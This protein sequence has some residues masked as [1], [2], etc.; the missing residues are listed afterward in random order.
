MEAYG[1]SSRRRCWGGAV[2]MVYVLLQLWPGASEG[3][4]FV[5]PFFILGAVW[6]P[7]TAQWVHLN[8]LHA[9]MNAMAAVLLCWF[10]SPWMSLKHQ[11]LALLGG[12]LGVALLL[13]LDTQCTYYAGASG[14]LHGVLAGAIAHLLRRAGPQRFAGAG[15][16]LALLTK[17][18]WQ[19]AHDGV[20][21]DWLGMPIYYPA[22]G[23]GA[24]GGAL[25]T[26]GLLVLVSYLHPPT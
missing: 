26:L 12:I 16:A 5:R 23:A 19:S 25:M 14:A 2:A 10:L 15:L 13:V 21:P 24:A 1:L 17:L 11:L 6:Q 18:Y 20:A 9:I 4:R 3:L 8:L 7:F 22:H